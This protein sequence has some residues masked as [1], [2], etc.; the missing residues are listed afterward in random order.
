[1]WFLQE[2]KISS[3]FISG[4]FKLIKKSNWR[5]LLICTLL[6]SCSLYFEIK[7]RD[8]TGIYLIRLYC[9]KYC[10][11]HLFQN[12]TKSR[13]YLFFHIPYRWTVRLHFL[14][15]DSH[16]VK[17]SSFHCPQ[18]A[19]LKSSSPFPYF[20]KPRKSFVI[21]ISELFLVC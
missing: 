19:K 5:L 21:S 17:D 7:F 13:N 20:W 4:N 12:P 16:L 6:G 11:A 18:L 2:R 1:M 9:W 15:W 3:W 10:T 8:N 14:W